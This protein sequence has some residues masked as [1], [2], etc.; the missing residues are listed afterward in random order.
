MDKLTKH[1]GVRFV[2]EEVDPSA[3]GPSPAKPEDAVAALKECLTR[4]ALTGLPAGWVTE[5]SQAALQAD[6]GLV[7]DLVEQIR[8]RHASIAEALASLVRSYRFDAIVK[9]V[10]ELGE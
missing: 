2:Y 3:Q 8:A 9:L 5:L 1:L 7:L 4:Q 6:G 10:E